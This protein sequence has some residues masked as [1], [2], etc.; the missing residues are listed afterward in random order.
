[1]HQSPQKYFAGRREKYVDPE[2]GDAEAE[3]R[4]HRG[5]QPKARR[6]PLREEARREE[7][8]SSRHPRG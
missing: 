6:F 1:M 2:A 4:L 8:E 3:R 5:T 7:R